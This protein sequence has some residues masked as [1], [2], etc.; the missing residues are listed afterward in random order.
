MFSASARAVLAAAAC[1]V[2][3]AAA[4]RAEQDGVVL[5]AS[6]E[7][8]W[9]AVR[10]SVAGALPLQRSEGESRLRTAPTAPTGRKASTFNPAGKVTAVAEWEAMEGVTVVYPF[11][12]PSTVIAD[13]SKHVTVVVLSS[14]PK[15]NWVALATKQLGGANM[16]NVKFMAG[17]KVNSP[18]VRDFGAVWARKEADGKLAIVDF[19]YNRPRPLDNAVP[20]AFANHLGARVD[21][22]DTGLTHTGGNFMVDGLGAAASTTLV[23]TESSQSLAQIKAVLRANLGVTAFTTHADPTGTYIEHIDCF[24]KWLTAT[25]VLVGRYKRADSRAADMDAAAA[26]LGGRSNGAGQA[27]TVH[28]VDIDDAPYVNR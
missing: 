19:E 27:F 22:V 8:E 10:A 24:A 26:E 25:D 13:F 18:W 15:N 4:A 9:A 5:L 17:V 21:Y 7:H 23:E 20:A 1:G 3:L 12:L 16:G 6:P 11:V 28:R 14:S 2:L